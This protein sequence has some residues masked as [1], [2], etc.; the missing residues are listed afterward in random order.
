MK[1][2]YIVIFDI[3]G[4]PYII[5][6]QS[7]YFTNRRC[8]ITAYE[9]QGLV[10]ELIQEKGNATFDHTKGHKVDFKNH[11]WILLKD[12]LSLSFSYLT[13]VIQDKI[14]NKDPCI[15]GNV[16]DLTPYNYIFNMNT[17]FI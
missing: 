6:D 8:M 7:V 16:F 2:E 10:S 13:F 3:H 14:E 9:I 4:C 15:E 5:T 12:A 17:A 11:N 1:E